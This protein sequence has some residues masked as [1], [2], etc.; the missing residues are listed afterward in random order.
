M[1]AE[2]EEAFSVKSELFAEGKG[3]FDVV[4]NGQLI[5][6]KYQT[7]RFPEHGE[8]TKLIRAKG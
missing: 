8:V 6:S 2:L 7:G 1:A 5:Y 3:I 4:V